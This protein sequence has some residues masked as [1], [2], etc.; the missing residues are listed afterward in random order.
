MLTV[1]Y[2]KQSQQVAENGATGQY[3]AE[4]LGAS[5]LDLEVKGKLEAV[6]DNAFHQAFA[7][8]GTY[9]NDRAPSSDA[10]PYAHLDQRGSRG[11]HGSSAGALVGRQ[12]LGRAAMIAV[13]EATDVGYANLAAEARCRCWV[14]A[15]QLLRRR[16]HPRVTGRAG[17]C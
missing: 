14:H 9:N 6:L 12:R 15:R 8:D 13:G 3:R 7:M 2:E 11:R 10:E 5:I 17:R 4:K 16:L 1:E